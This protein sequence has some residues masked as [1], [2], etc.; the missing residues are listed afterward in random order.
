MAQNVNKDFTSLSMSDL[1]VI[2]DVFFL[3]NITGLATLS[4][5]SLTE[6]GAIEWTGLAVLSTLDF[7]QTVQ[8]ASILDIQDTGLSSLTGIDLMNV[9]FLKITNNRFL[10][11]VDMKLKNVTTGATIAANGLNTKVS[12]PD[13]T[14]AY[15]MTLWN[16]SS[17]SLPKLT[18]V[19][20]SIGFHSN[21]FDTLSVP[22]LQSVSGSLSIISNGHL[23]SA[24]F[25]SLKGV[26]GGIAIANNSQ[27]FD[28]DG[29]PQLLVVG[30]AIDM[31]GTFKK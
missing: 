21:F 15:N 9:N 1:S 14:W 4:F 3:S 19:N 24:S 31:F 7:T 23:S 22:K 30:G 5:P 13:L 20:E 27:L 2:D 18:A 16:V 29:F 25:P 28:V 10:T 26:K 11:E 17:L 12:F 8:K 6:V